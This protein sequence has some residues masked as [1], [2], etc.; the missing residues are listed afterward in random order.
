VQTQQVIMA[1]EA[2]GAETKVL[3][4]QI[5]KR[6]EDGALLSNKRYEEQAAFNAQVSQDLQAVRKQIDLTQA[7]V[8]EARQV[9]SAVTSPVMGCSQPGD[10]RAAAAAFVA[11]GLGMPGYPRLANDGAPLIPVAPDRCASY[12]ELYKTPAQN[13]VT[14]ASLYLEGRAALWWQVMR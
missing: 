14:T 12:F 2:S 11:S 4:D 9:A 8:D 6:L 13:R 7:D 1:L 10:H 5:L 3:L